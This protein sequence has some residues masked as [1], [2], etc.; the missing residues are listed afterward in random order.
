M[1]HVTI[2]SN[3]VTKINGG[4]SAPV[5]G[6]NVFVGAGAKIIGPV[7]IGNNVKIG[8]G[9]V[10]VTDVPD[11]AVVVMHKPRILVGGRDVTAE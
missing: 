9:A 1:Q 6:D 3:F 5:L 8:A 10:V 11:D 7:R 4:G 2:G